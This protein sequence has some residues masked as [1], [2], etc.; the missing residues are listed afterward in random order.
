M[1]VLSWD[2]IRQ[3]GY[4]IVIYPPLRVIMSCCDL[5]MDLYIPMDFV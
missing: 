3:V 4:E 5:F 2:D 1:V